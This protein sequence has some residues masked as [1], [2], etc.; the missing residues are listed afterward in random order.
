ML[1][2]FIFTCC[3]FVRCY[4]SDS[5]TG[6]S[7]F[8]F[9]FNRKCPYSLAIALASTVAKE[10]VHRIVQR[11]SQQQQQQQQQQ[12]AAAVNSEAGATGS[13]VS[14][15][16][17]TSTQANVT[18][19]TTTVPAQGDSLVIGTTE[20]SSSTVPSNAVESS[21][22]SSVNLADSTVSIGSDSLIQSSSSTSNT[23]SVASLTSS[24]LIDSGVLTS[25]SNSL[26]SSLFVS[27]SNPIGFV[28]SS[29]EI[30]K[31]STEI[32]KQLTTAL[33]TGQ[34]SSLISLAY[35]FYTGP[36]VSIASEK[37]GRRT[38]EDRHVII[39][40]LNKVCGLTS[41]PRQY[42][43]Y[44]VFDGHV[45]IEAA[46][47]SASHLH[48]N[49]VENQ[50][51]SDGDIV[52]ALKV[53]FAKTDAEY[54]ERAALTEVKTG[55]TAVVCVK[56]D[57]SKLYFA[58]AGDSQA[59]LVKDGQALDI[60][61]AH[62]P[63]NDAER[64]RIESLGGTVLQLDTW[65][66][67]GV[68]A[69][70]RA[71]GDP[72]HKKFVTADPDIVTIPLE[73]NE[74]FI[75]IACDGLWDHL[76]PDDAM[77]L[78]YE[79]L[80]SNSFN[81]PHDAANKVSEY[82]LEKAKAEGS[83]DNITA[84]VV[85]LRDIRQLLPT[86]AS[87]SNG[88]CFDT[89]SVNTCVP[90]NNMSVANSSLNDSFVTAQNTSKDDYSE[91]AAFTPVSSNGDQ[92]PTADLYHQGIFTTPGD[93]EVVHLT[94]D[95][96]V[97][98]ASNL[99]QQEDFFATA[100]SPSDAFITSDSNGQ[101]NHVNNFGHYFGGD[102]NNP[103]NNGPFDAS[104]THK[105]TSSENFDSIIFKEGETI[106]DTTAS[107]PS[108]L[109]EMDESVQQEERIEHFDDPSP[110]PAK[111]SKVS[112]SGSLFADE[113]G[114]KEAT[115]PF[116]GNDDGTFSPTD[117]AGN[118]ENAPT[119][120]LSRVDLFATDVS[121]KNK[122]MESNDSYL[123]DPESGFKEETTVS[124]VGSTPT[125][126]DE[127]IE[128]QI[129]SG[130]TSP[131][132]AFSPVKS[133]IENETTCE[134]IRCESV[135]GTES[136]S[137]DEAESPA[138]SATGA[139][140]ASTDMHHEGGI[141]S[142]PADE[143]VTLTPQPVEAE[144]ASEMYQQE[145][146]FGTATSPSSD[147]FRATDSGGQSNHANTFDHYFT[148]SDFANESNNDPFN[149][150]SS[151]RKG[152]SSN[153]NFD[154]VIFK[155][156]VTIEETTTTTIVPSTTLEEVEETTRYET[157]TKRSPSPPKESKASYGES[158]FTDEF[159]TKETTATPFAGNGN[160]YET[161]TTFERHDDTTTTTAAANGLLNDDLFTTASDVTIEKSKETESND[162]YLIK[163]ESEFKEQIT[164]T[165]LGSTSTDK[166]EIIERQFSSGKASPSRPLS[167][168]KSPIK[169][170]TV[171]EIIKNEAA[172]GSKS[173]TREGAKSPAKGPIKGSARIIGATGAAAVAAAAAAIGASALASSK[174]SSA[175]KAT[176]AATK[177]TPSA[178]KTTTATSRLKSTPAP[179]KTSTSVLKAST[180][181]TKKPIASSSTCATGVNSLASSGKTTTSTGRTT[182]T[183]ATTTSTTRSSTINRSAVPS[184][185][186]KTVSTLSK[187]NGTSTLASKKLPSSTAGATGGVSAKVNGAVTKKS[188]STSI[189]GV[190]SRLYPGPKAPT[191]TSTTATSTSS[192]LATRRPLASSTSSKA[193][194]S[195]ARTSTATTTASRSSTITRTV[196]STK[197]RP[198]V[199][200]LS[201]VNGT[202]STLASK[203]AAPSTGVKN[204]VPAKVNGTVTKK[205]TSITG[206]SSRLYPGP[207][208]TTASATTSTTTPVAVVTATAA[209]TS[210]TQVTASET[211]ITATATTTA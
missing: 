79:F 206:V 148:G 9:I 130:A 184:T 109:E 43:Y 162:S 3:F 122:E 83:T 58:W 195:A 31:E 47:Y 143:A 116:A 142:S 192:T 154:S 67:S 165:R 125:V 167:P 155:E 202:S 40:D 200:A 140:V 152:T 171:S 93:D 10:T 123:I 169:S 66:V 151:T 51:F 7:L 156:E 144:Q 32:L 110:L 196:P 77:S 191:T 124:T 39:H 161:S 81:D 207:K 107:V 62:K 187:V 53:A 11:Q 102:F 101:N 5:L 12:A 78:I 82:L 106:D 89:S 49:F 211:S 103:A 175:S 136:P 2:I 177:S 74:D 72:E 38:M 208:A 13:S 190:S 170:E 28:G 193:T 48:H 121:E 44:A 33:L 8:P 141:S 30:K 52:D 50:A 158:L 194:T 188:T 180:L 120:G 75:V 34:L 14:V 166:E 98:R 86:Y 61:P 150:L 134:V 25:T 64:E 198:A 76:T 132:E 84:I 163:T 90:A 181:A 27:S 153:E 1:C 131:S 183:A 199:S 23:P 99:Y 68:L 118:N 19:S 159:E 203:K 178:S 115:S 65:R 57:N 20:V 22:N 88:N 45:G 4:S 18:A 37:N 55:C 73:G 95:S 128:R 69:V 189:T 139:T 92:R 111:E 87:D 108:T 164:T 71:I 54:L 94:P 145:D 138:K 209:T 17:V 91:V 160:A 174:S 172:S 42:S 21:C 113:F 149:A 36:L 135:S 35:S 60:T 105:T 119:N 210:A 56:E 6:F 112:Y 97:D 59:I 146:L 147:A 133:P 41:C 63:A 80:A 104:N 176:P 168:A 201:K 182:T 205:T 197:P 127:L 24:S 29:E 96:Q 117:D 46:T 26:N 137:R 204:G 114:N 70:S 186:P 157:F 85:F 129:A 16:E 126:D 173:P 185:K 15:N 100:N 179:S